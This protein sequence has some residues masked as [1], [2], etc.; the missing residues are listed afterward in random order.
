MLKN[1]YRIAPSPSYQQ[2]GVCFVANDKGLFIS[3]DGCQS[4]NNTFD[5]FMKGNPL[6]CTAVA[7]SPDYSNDRTIFA[8]ISGGIFYSQDNAKTWQAIQ[9]P[10][11]MPIIS[12][13]MPSPDFKTDHTI[14]AATTEDGVY[15]SDNGGQSWKTWNFG[16]FDMNIYDMAVSPNFSKNKCVYLGTETGV[17]LS[18][19]GG[20]H[21]KDAGFPM[22]KAAVLSI[23]AV[24]MSDGAELVFAGTENNGLFIS[25]DCCKCWQ[26]VAGAPIKGAINQISLAVN[27]TGSLEITLLVEDRIIQS[28]NGGETWSTRYQAPEG[29]SVITCFADIEVETD[30]KLYFLGTIGDGLI[31][32]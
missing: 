12:V 8:G 11:P 15:F 9:F 7:F 22:E 19:N 16:L 27:K 14:F 28:N 32:I 29:L 20:C 3:D 13:I 10:T 24:K 1:I 18:T 31:K 26:P 6:S 4:W 5:T 21:W 23:A 25:K 30:K 2:D 17:F